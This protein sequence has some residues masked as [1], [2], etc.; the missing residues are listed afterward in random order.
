MSVCMYMEKII[1]LLS[2]PFV[3]DLASI[4]RQQVLF[5]KSH[6]NILDFESHTMNFSFL[7]WFLLLYQYHEYHVQSYTS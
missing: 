5:L 7:P 6:T 2:E 3:L 4:K 1:Y